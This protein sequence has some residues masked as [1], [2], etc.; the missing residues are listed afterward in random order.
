MALIDCPECENEVSESADSCPSCGYPFGGQEANEEN[1]RKY[2]TASF[3]ESFNP[4]TWRWGSWIFGVIGIVLFLFS[5]LIIGDDQFSFPKIITASFLFYLSAVSIR[6]FSKPEQFGNLDQFILPIMILLVGGIATNEYFEDAGAP[7]LHNDQ[8]HGTTDRTT[9]N[10][11]EVPEESQETEDSNSDHPIPLLEVDRD[12]V[13]SHMESFQEASDEPLTTDYADHFG[14]PNLADDVGMDLLERRRT[15]E[16]PERDFRKIGPMISYYFLPE[17]NEPLTLL[18]V[19]IDRWGLTEE[20]FDLF[21]KA[22]E[23]SLG[24]SFDEHFDL[25][26]DEAK[27]EYDAFTRN[28]V[29]QEY[30]SEA[31]VWFAEIGKGTFESPI[32]DGIIEEPEEFSTIEKEINEVPVSLRMDNDYISLRIGEN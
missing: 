9:L 13:K 10:H 21:K 15:S 18:H 32:E 12:F 14:S 4:K 16:F 17:D 11:E 31:Y 30:S 22:F 29:N 6:Y 24:E 5:L 8:T 26:Y 19:S 23:N 20:H 28:E 25:S 27:I 7:T 3:I 2:K 1:K